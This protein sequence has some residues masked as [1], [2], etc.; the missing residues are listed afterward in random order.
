MRMLILAQNPKT[1]HN[2]T[3]PLQGTKSWT[4]LN[5]WLKEARIPL[6]LLELR[7]AYRHTGAETPTASVTTGL[8]ESGEWVSLILGYPVIVALGRYAANAVLRTREAYFPNVKDWDH[9][10]LPH[11]SGLNRKLN[12]PEEHIKAVQTLRKAHDK[13]LTLR[14]YE[15]RIIL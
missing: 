4:V 2:L 12:D 15:G 8:V 3:N 10:F 13:F 1:A 6:E 9:F 7:N 5:R 14:E 11:P